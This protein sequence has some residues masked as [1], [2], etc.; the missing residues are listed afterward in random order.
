MS[1]LEAKVAGLVERLEAGCR[2]EGYGPRHFPSIAKR[3]L[4]EHSV[5]GGWSAAD[6]VE[7]VAER[8]GS[9]SGLDVL[10]AMAQRD[11]L[12]I[13]GGPAAQEALPLYEGPRFSVALRLVVDQLGAPHSHEW[14]G[15]YQVVAGRAL[16]VTYAFA[17]QLDVDAMFALGIMVRTG[18]EILGPG[19]TLEIDAGERL[20]HSLSH[21]ERPGLALVVKTT[22][23]LGAASPFFMW[24][25]VMVGSDPLPTNTTR[26]LRAL[27]AVFSVDRARWLKTLEAALTDADL[28]TAFFLLRYATD[29]A[30]GRVS[31]DS[32]F[33]AADRTFGIHGPI[34]RRAIARHAR[35]GTLLERFRA[36]ESAGERLVVASLY[37]ANDEADAELL[38]EAARSRS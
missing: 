19:S 31:L 15:A 4:A 27:D 11:A 23:R 24:P 26:R 8:D 34:V 21:F 37:V 2:A 33:A 3:A 14:C 9:K 1:E 17:N 18:A 32:L 29:R 36:A 38:A 28:R 16:H 25:G 22:E 13:G 35:E 6:L 10:E 5:F 30:Q 7:A 20:I 12:R